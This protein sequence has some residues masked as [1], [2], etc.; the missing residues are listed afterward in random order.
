[1]D[2]G[3]L[4]VGEVELGNAS[5]LE[6]AVAMIAA[7]RSFEASMQAIQ[8]YRRLDERSVEVGRVR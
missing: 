4:R 2:D 7:Q 6:S 1:V 5:A 3:R 8:T